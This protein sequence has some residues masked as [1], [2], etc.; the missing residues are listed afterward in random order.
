MVEQ[1]MLP[2]IP[3]KR[4]RR[5]TSNLTHNEKVKLRTRERR[6]RLRAGGLR[7]M[8]VWVPEAV[9]QAAT[10]AA[11]KANKPRDHF[12]AEKLSGIFKPSRKSHT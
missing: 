9:L 1:F 4:G 3:K 6:V 10:E 7:S 8:T 2:G 5:P 12:V 11:R